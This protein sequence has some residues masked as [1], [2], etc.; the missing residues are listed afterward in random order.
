MKSIKKRM[1]I[2]WWFKTVDFFLYLTNN[3]VFGPNSHN[4]NR[5]MSLFVTNML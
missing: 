3:T 2:K 4:E 1:F 5:G